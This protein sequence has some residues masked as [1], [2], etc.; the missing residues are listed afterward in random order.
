[1]PPG[2]SLPQPLPGLLSEATPSRSHQADVLVP[3]EPGPATEHG[4]PG[5]SASSQLRKLPCSA[6]QSAKGPLSEMGKDCWM[7]SCPEQRYSCVSS[8]LNW[9]TK[10][11][12]ALRL[13]PAPGVLLAQLRPARAQLE[14]GCGRVAWGA[15]SPNC[16]GR[17][18]LGW[19]ISYTLRRL[20]SPLQKH[21]TRKVAV[22][23]LM[24]CS[25]RLQQPLQVMN[26]AQLAPCWTHGR[27]QYARLLSWEFQ[28]QQ[29]FVCLFFLRCFLVHSVLR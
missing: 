26:P 7:P 16:I 29:L 4:S 15:T 27:S 21:S 24:G 6:P 23:V 25:R 11:R 17:D 22:P 10:R 19:D 8:F 13:D 2:I 28:L 12:W 20:S 18:R 9:V 5:S 3:G 1:M 14:R